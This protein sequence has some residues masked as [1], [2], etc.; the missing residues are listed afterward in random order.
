MKL[1]NIGT[2]LLR[3]KREKKFANDQ[4]GLNMTATLVRLLERQQ[5]VI[6]YRYDITEI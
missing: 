6:K 5:E 4:E 2:I 3:Y 1:S